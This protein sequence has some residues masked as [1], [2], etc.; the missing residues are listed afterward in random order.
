MKKLK[1]NYSKYFLN[2][3]ILFSLASC[4]Q[5]RTEVTICSTIHG[6]HK[7]NQLYSYEDLY[8]FVDLLDLDIIGVEIRQTD[9][10]SSLNY[11]RSNYPFEMYN[12]KY[13]YHHK[14]VV[15]F[16]WLG[17]EVEGRGIPYNYWTNSSK[18]KKLERKLNKDTIVMQ[19]LAVADRI[20]EEKVE[21]F[22]SSSLYQLNKGRY[23]TLNEEYYRELDKKLK[24]TRYHYIPD[25]IVK[26][27]A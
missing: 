13:K 27:T 20:R 11:L 16:D 14:K 4:Q 6:S 8:E 9:L 24:S 3:L 5:V 17:E 18:V 12:C 19:N 2:V 1:Y 15:G 21:I 23:D 26:E 22:L 7:N 25:F 10:D